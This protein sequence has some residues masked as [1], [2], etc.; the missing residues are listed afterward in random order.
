MKKARQCLLAATHTRRNR[1]RS[2]QKLRLLTQPQQQEDDKDK[3][4][5]TDHAAD[6]ELAD[7]VVRVPQL[8][9]LAELDDE[10]GEGL[11][12]D[13]ASDKTEEL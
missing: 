8:S 13:D 10:T 12:D 7:D 3:S 4:L 5:I 1:C 6:S 11:L 9:I 2:L